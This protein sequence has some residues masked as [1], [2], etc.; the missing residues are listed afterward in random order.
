MSQDRFN[1]ISGLFASPADPLLDFPVVQQSNFWDFLSD[2]DSNS[3]LIQ[4]NSV[5]KGAK[6][7]VLERAQL[8]ELIRAW[9]KATDEKLL[10]FSWK[11]VDESLF[12]EQFDWSQ[13]K[14]ESGELRKT[15]PL[16]LQSADVHFSA[17]HLALCLKN[18]ILKEHSGWSYGF[19][20]NGAGFLG[21]S[22][23]LIADWSASDGSFLTAALAGTF[24]ADVDAD[25]AWKD[26]KTLDE[27]QIVVQDMYEQILKEV[28]LDFVV[29]KDTQLHRLQH[30]SHFKT[31]FIC[32]N[33]SAEQ[34]LRLI[35]RLHPTAA[36]GLYPRHP[37]FFKE[38]SVL[39]LQKI[40][41]Q[42]AAPFTWIQSDRILSVGMI[43]N[44]FFD[45][46]QVQIFS[47]CGVTQQSHLASELVELR[48]K[49]NAVKKMMGFAI[50][51]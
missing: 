31:D 7:V 2:L 16:I 47:G 39:N 19:W 18:L 27:H 44:F 8:L 26:D 3:H 36:L 28:S 35:R 33:V 41:K 21:H 23:E 9:L 12:V 22:P 29:K 51:E 32:Q 15:V 6:S 13:K 25:T 24:L 30:L 5:W 43:R 10:Q 17:E 42:F 45:E 48:N 1:L 38:L 50:D 14:F 46:K 40:R 11:A 4:S 20:Q 37:K 34:S 49:R